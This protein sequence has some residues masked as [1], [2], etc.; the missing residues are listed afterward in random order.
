MPFPVHRRGPMGW[1]GRNDISPAL[2]RECQS[3]DVPGLTPDGHTPVQKW[4]T[5][6]LP[7]AV[8]SFVDSVEAWVC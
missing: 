4:E 6:P 8:I 7:S 2:L 5:G 1:S 3:N